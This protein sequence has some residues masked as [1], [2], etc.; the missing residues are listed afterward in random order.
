MSNLSA[1]LRTLDK[2]PR[3]LL[4]EVK[5]EINTFIDFLESK[6]VTE[7]EDIDE[8]ISQIKSEGYVYQF[9][10]RSYLEILVTKEEN[11][12]DKY[13]YEECININ[14]ST[15]RFLNSYNEIF[16]AKE[17]QKIQTIMDFS[18]IKKNSSDLIPSFEERSEK[19]HNYAAKHYTI[20]FNNYVNEY[21]L[22][23]MSMKIILNKI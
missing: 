20:I 12:S 9:K 5:S 21:I 1:F 14:I 23:L 13:K 6:Y 10:I 8:K 11:Q 17:N 2:S 19:I 4:S 18:K 15:G 16:N 3:D 22:V 7:S